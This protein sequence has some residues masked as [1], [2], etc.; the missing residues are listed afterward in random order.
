LKKFFQNRRFLFLK[1]LAQHKKDKKH[2]I[3]SYK[4]GQTSACDKFL[5]KMTWRNIYKQVINGT[6]LKRVLLK[7]HFLYHWHQ[8]FL[9][10][11]FSS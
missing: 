10:S 4:K 5:I 8:V 6:W 9:S 1:I 7:G 11:C 2:F 3:E